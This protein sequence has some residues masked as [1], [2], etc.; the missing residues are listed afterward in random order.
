MNPR[1]ARAIA[2]QDALREGRG[3]Y[4]ASNAAYAAALRAKRVGEA[5]QRRCAVGLKPL[6]DD[7]HNPLP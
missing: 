3:A 5:I 4:A 6:P 2:Y 7:P 1:I